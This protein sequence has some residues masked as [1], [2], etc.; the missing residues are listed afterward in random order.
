[1]Q[2]VRRRTFL[3]WTMQ[4]TPPVRPNHTPTVDHVTTVKPHKNV[5][6]LL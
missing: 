6:L 1:M 4:G 3:H 5:M 2:G